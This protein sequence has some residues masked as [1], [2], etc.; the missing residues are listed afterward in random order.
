[1][2]TDLLWQNLKAGTPVP[3]QVREK[4]AKQIV[5]AVSFAHSNEVMLGTLHLSHF[6]VD[7][8]NNIK[9]VRIK[10]QPPGLWEEQVPETKLKPCGLR[11]MDSA[12]TKESDVFQLGLVL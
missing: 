6:G 3:W 5:E 12:P 7:D 9:L 1:M 4:W 2:V 10:R 11:R 8:E